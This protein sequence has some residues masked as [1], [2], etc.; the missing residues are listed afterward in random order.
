[1]GVSSWI[2][3]LLSVSVPVLSE[4]SMFMPASSSIAARRATIAFFAT[5]CRL[6]I[7]IVVVVTTSIA[8]GMEATSSTTTKPIA[9]A[10][11]SPRTSR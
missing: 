4:H 9:L 7:A 11:G 8:S 10:P 1:M 5:S 2:I 6:P 3:I